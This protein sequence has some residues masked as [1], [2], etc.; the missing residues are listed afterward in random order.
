[1]KKTI[2]IVLTI[3]LALGIVLLILWQI[4]NLAVKRAEEEEAKTKVTEN[5]PAQ[6]Y[7]KLLESLMPDP[8]ASSTLSAEEYNELSASLAPSN[9]ASTTMDSN[10]YQ[11]LIKSLEPQQ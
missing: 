7:E 10:T 6:E 4:N 5:T 1:M 9:V 2:Y 11:E 3:I 8:N